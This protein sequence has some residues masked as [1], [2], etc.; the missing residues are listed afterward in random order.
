MYH[1]RSFFAR[2]PIPLFYKTLNLGLHPQLTKSKAPRALVSG[3]STALATVDLFLTPGSGF[4]V[5][6]SG[7][8]SQLESR[9]ER[10]R[11]VSKGVGSR[12]TES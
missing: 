11:K 10:P 8:T 4:R 2:C 5:Q 3:R 9:A 12:K 6:G 1:L 7:F